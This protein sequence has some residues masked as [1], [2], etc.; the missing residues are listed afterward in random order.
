[1][2]ADGKGGGLKQLDFRDLL[3][4]VVLQNPIRGMVG[5]VKTQD[6]SFPRIF[7]CSDEDLP[8]V[9]CRGFKSLR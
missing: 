4:S 3:K 6:R 8:N 1:M 9:S 7:N 5:A 2:L